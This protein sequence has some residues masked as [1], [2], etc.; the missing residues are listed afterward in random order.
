VQ[1]SL[2]NSRRRG[3]DLAE[4]YAVADEVLAAVYP[5][6]RFATAAFGTLDVGSGRFRWIS[7]GHPAPLL[8]RGGEVEGEAQ[9][10]PTVPIGLRH[11]EPPTINEVMLAPGDAL[12]L[13]TDGVTEG[14]AR[15][16]ERFGLER[17]VDVLRG[18]LIEG[19]P[20]AEILRRLIVAVLEHTAYELHDDAGIVLVQRRTRSEA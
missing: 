12:V 2:R 3:L 6:L 20:P 4:A 15:G 19:L 9:V 16:G 17:F 10:V 13:Y 5:D 8:I 1:G 11:R 14:G 18:V 7:A